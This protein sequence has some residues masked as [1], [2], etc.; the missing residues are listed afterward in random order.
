MKFKALQTTELSK[1]HNL[2]INFLN[3]KFLLIE[4]NHLHCLS[5]KVKI[6]SFILAKIG[7]IFAFTSCFCLQGSGNQHF[8]LSG[9]EKMLSKKQLFEKFFDHWQICS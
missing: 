8:G 4:L 7:I 1:F 5:S 3:S 2:K 6:S 9:F